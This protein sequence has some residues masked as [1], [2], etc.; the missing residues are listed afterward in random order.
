MKST[1]SKDR[2][3]FNQPRKSNHT[4]KRIEVAALPHTRKMRFKHPGQASINIYQWP[5][6]CDLT[7]KNGGKNIKEQPFFDRKR[8]FYGI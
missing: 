8:A 3:E 5:I 6:N 7:N 1:E 4:L 2:L